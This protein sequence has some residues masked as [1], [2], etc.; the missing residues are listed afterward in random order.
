MVRLVLVTG[1]R[2]WRDPA[3]IWARLDDLLAEHQPLG[4]CLIIINGMAKS[5]VDLIAHVWT[6][7]QARLHPMHV[8]E[9]PFPADWTNL[10]RK[11]GVIRNDEMARLGADYCL[12]WIHPCTSVSCRRAEPHGSHGATDCVARARTYQVPIIESVET[13]TEEAV[14]HPNLL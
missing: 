3:P 10:G 2:T 5:G 6:E 14:P 13:W 4:R 1:S 11:A 8:K 9:W 7:E 12:A